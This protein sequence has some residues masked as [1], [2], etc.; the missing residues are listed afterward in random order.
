MIAGGVHI[1]RPVH[2]HE[3]A[4]KLLGGFR[5]GCMEAGGRRVVAQ[6]GELR[7]TGAIMSNIACCPCFVMAEHTHA[8]QS[9]KF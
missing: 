6:N 4:L 1:S 5:Q 2:G 9:R 3:S 7:S 8:A